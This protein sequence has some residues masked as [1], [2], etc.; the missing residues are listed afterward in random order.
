[1]VA[2]CLRGAVKVLAAGL[3]VLLWCAVN[4]VLAAQPLSAGPLPPEI[5]I[6]VTDTSGWIY[7]DRKGFTL[8]IWPTGDFPMKS[9]CTD[10]RFV[11][12]TVNT[13][14][15]KYY[16]PDADKRPTCVQSTPPL[17][18]EANAKPAGDWAIFER[19]DGAKQ[20]AWKGHPV[21]RSSLDQAPGDVNGGGFFNYLLGGAVRNSRIP[22]HADLIGVPP[23][24]TT[25]E[26]PAGTILTAGENK[27]LYVRK[28]AGLIKASAG[29]GLDCETGW[30]PFLAPTLA[31]PAG[32][33]SVLTVAR[34]LRQW[35][36]RGQ[37]L[38]TYDR[39]VLDP[40]VP[41][42]ATPG[43]APAVVMP[44][45]DPPKGVTV[46][47]TIEGPAYADAKGHTLY[48]FHC[49]DETPDQLECDVKGT[50]QK[51]R[52]SLCGGPDLCKERFRP[53]YAH[54]GDKAPNH[55]WTV[56]KIDKET[57]GRMYDESQE[58]LYAWAHRGRP[59][60]TFYLDTVPGDAYAHEIQ[61]HLAGDWRMIQVGT[62]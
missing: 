38:F 28:G 2:K 61:L 11:R 60:Y 42:D 21:Y 3:A 46:Q 29:C 4:P 57:L 24:V 58:G 43:W 8:Y 33:W 53:L 7:T 31:T 6:G 17:L 59:L 47:M 25:E 39:V 23:G 62:R 27:P 32:D 13:S 50:S 10:E 41:L 19:P 49:I 5:R 40:Q 26:T 48:T 12:A 15:A 37:A 30:K 36:Y 44:L 54:K 14:D 55:T 51:V 1:M 22:I 18:A 35:A 45:P 52:L 16:M 20:W 9:N 56:V 34:G